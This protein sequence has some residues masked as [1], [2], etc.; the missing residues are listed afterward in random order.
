[1]QNN[2][3]ILGSSSSGNSA[4]LNTGM[5]KILIDA[6]FSS[7]QLELKLNNI[8][9]TI[10]SL[11]AVFLTHEHTDHSKGTIALSTNYDLPIFSN[12]DTAE[13]I[14]NK[15][16]K[17]INWK[18]FNTGSSFQFKDLLIKSY[19]I[20]HDASDPVGLS[21]Y[22]DKNETDDQY[23]NSLAWITDL[24][25]IPEHI[26]QEVLKVKSLVIECNYDEKLLNDDKKRPWH[27][28]QRIKSRHGHLSNHKT[29]SF[30]EEII[31]ISKL[32]KIFLVHLSKEC[33]DYQ[34]VEKKISDLKIN[35]SDLNI[36]VI[37]PDKQWI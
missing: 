37:D 34:I 9:E 20:P 2:F 22:W 13:V 35:D 11:D 17:D 8:G 18:I 23:M 27:L 15:T 21:F 14:Q 29:F 30:L 24:G 3:K 31:N 5:T 19:S 32:K 16:K 6:G 1:M 12:K 26:K 7:K 28:K 4:F 10:N 25:Y 33:N 36:K